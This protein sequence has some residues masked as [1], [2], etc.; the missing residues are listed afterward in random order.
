MPPLWETNHIASVIFIILSILS[1]VSPS[2]YR[3]YSPGIFRRTKHPIISLKIFQKF[4]VKKIKKNINMVSYFSSQTTIYKLTTPSNSPSVSNISQTTYK[5][6]LY[7]DL[8]VSDT[9]VPPMAFSYC[10]KSIF[11][12]FI[13]YSFSYLQFTCQENRCFLCLFFLRNLCDGSDDLNPC[14]VF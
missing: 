7:S 6:C 9:K 11:K 3:P 14:G 8:F 5:Y 12:C 1:P 2:P 13:Q 10:L 4:S